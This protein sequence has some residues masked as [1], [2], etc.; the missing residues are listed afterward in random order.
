MAKSPITYTLTALLCAV[1]LFSC[2]TP[3]IEPL[4]DLDEQNSSSDTEQPPTPPLSSQ[5]SNRPSSSSSNPISSPSNSSSSSSVLKSSSSSSPVQTNN[6]CKEFNPKPDFTCNWYGYT[7]GSV[8][9]PGKILEPIYD[10]LPDDCSSIAWKYA[11][12]TAAL[13]LNYECSEID[14]YGFAALGSRNYVLFAELSCKDGKHT[15]ACNP[16][17]GWPSKRAPELVGECKWSKNPTSTAKGATPS[18][19]SIVDTDKICTNP[20]IVY[21]YDGGTKILPINGSIEAG[22]YNDVEATLNCPAYGEPV[23]ALCPPLRVDA[24]ADYLITCSGDQIDGRNCGM[25]TPYAE[26]KVGN[27]ECIDLEINWTS[28]YFNPSIAMECS[29]SFTMSDG[30]YP[31]TSLSI[32]VGNNPE[33][34]RKGEL[35]V[36]NLVTVL[37][38]IQVGTTEVLGIC[39]SYT[40]TQT[41]PSSVTCSLRVN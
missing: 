34:T 6:G 16:K 23:T 1:L 33:V 7:A 30:T 21:K 32:K 8:L 15:N 29:G 20:T 13:A 22:K 27:G 2:T 14:D 18:G 17:T 28:Q 19:V 9:A 26:I 31:N 3:E 35:Y 38:K 24:G 12:D 39:V 40:S 25:S 4:P 10:D 5:P 11:P 37:N 41:I 36:S